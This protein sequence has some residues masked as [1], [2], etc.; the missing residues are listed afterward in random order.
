MGQLKAPKSLVW[1]KKN[2]GLNKGCTSKGNKAGHGGKVA[3]SFV[4]LSL[5][6]G[7]CYFKHYEKL[8]DKLF[9]EFIENNFLEILK[10]SCNP[11][12]MCL[13]KMVIQVKTPKL[14]KLL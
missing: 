8:S 12:G 7:I 4:A 1:R 6:K 14:L 13:F 11:Q 3:S 5:G 10:S 2:E 9:G